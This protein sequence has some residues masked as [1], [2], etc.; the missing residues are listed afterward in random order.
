VLS[1]VLALVFPAPLT[2]PFSVK[3][4]VTAEFVPRLVISEI[5]SPGVSG[6]APREGCG[7]TGILLLYS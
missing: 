5:L 7:F 6:T 4:S 1:A 3:L 2:P